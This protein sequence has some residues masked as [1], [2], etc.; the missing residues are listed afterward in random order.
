[1]M[2]ATKGDGALNVILLAAP[3]QYVLFMPLLLSIM[4]FINKLDMVISS[5]VRFDP[6]ISQAMLMLYFINV[7]IKSRRLLPLIPTDL[8]DNNFV[9]HEQIGG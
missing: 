1:M 6:Y 9:N 8:C 2:A 4:Y 7:W 5:L 3:T